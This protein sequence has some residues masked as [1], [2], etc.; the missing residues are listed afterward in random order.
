MGVA[1]FTGGEDGSALGSDD[2]HMGELEIGERASSIDWTTHSGVVNPVKD[3]GQCGSCW[4]FSAVGTVES[5]YAL[6][7][8]RLGSYSEQQ[9]VDCDTSRSQGCQG[10]FNQYGISYIGQA[11]SC[12]ESSYPYKATDGTCVASQCT[13]S[14][15]AGTVTGYQSVTGSNAGLESALNTQP[16]SVTVK[17]DNTWQSYRSGVVSQNCGFFGR[18]N[19]AVIAV[20][21]DGESFKIRNSWGATWGEQGYIRVSNSDSNPYCL[22]TTTPFVPT[23]SAD[24]TAL[25]SS[26][27]REKYEEW[28][29][30][31]GSNGAEDEF[32]VFSSNLRAMEAAQAND[33]SATYSHLT[34]FANI[35][36]DDFK[37]RNGYR[38]TSGATQAPLLDVSNVAANIEGVGAVE[39]GKLLSLSEQQLVDCDSVDQGCNGG[40]P[41]NTFQFYSGGVSDPSL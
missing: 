13:K 30:L 41:S 38:A 1:Q 31:Y 5:A 37:T 17:A 4:A 11:G 6:A 35:S 22:W 8:G 15:P 36:P 27:D 26:S 12:S 24:V 14:L 18:P 34:P 29:A 19:H 28:K 32:E 23:L 25:G 9:L 33:P 40:L 16:V 2:V 21:Y 7:A 39:T 20:G 3:Q 10:G